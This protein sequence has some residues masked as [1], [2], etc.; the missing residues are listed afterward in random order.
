[1]QL[2][3][4]KQQLEN[5]G[6]VVQQ[7]RAAV[8]KCV[9]NTSFKNI[10][11][12]GFIPENI[13]VIGNYFVI[14]FLFLLDVMAGSGITFQLLYIFP[15]IF[16]ALHSS[17]TN[18]V[19]GAVALSVFL[20]FIEL[21]FFQHHAL[22][23]QL[24]L[25]LMIAFSN[26]ICALLARY[27]RTNT[28][29][30][31]HLSTIDS[32][33]RLFNR[34]ALENALIAEIVRQRRYGGRFSVAVIDL[35]GFKGL[36]DSMGHQAGDEALNLLADILRNNTRQTD[37]LARPGGDEFVVV[38][39]NTRAADCNALCHL[40]CQKIAMR[41]LDVFSY[42]IT[43]SIGFTTIENPNTTANDILAIADRAMYQAK[44]LGKNGVVRGYALTEE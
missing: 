13:T 38:M 24:H 28:L 41:M 43:A 10:A 35:D 7:K 40:F 22:E 36:N 5:R 44:L 18:L 29:E 37:M 30:A 14:L 39:P 20:Q 16:I 23:M 1:M 42:P 3:S 15:L 21:L 2:I 6:N 31:R 34:G 25:F 11:S 27:S 17:R 19:I 4:R 12:P 33:T 8:F 32:L 26:G 9:L